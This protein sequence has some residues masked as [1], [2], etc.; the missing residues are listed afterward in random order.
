MLRIQLSVETKSLLSK[1]SEFLVSLV[2]HL[3]L[4]SNES[5]LIRDL[6]SEVEVN[7]VINT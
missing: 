6:L 1:R 5:L 3:F 2:T 4:L 7:L